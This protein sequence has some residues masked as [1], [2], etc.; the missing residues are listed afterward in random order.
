MTDIDAPVLSLIVT[1]RNDDHGGNLLGRMQLFIDGWIDQCRR[2]SL[3]SELIIV[4]WNPPAERP[5]LADALSWPVETGPVRV[6]IIQVPND[7]HR[8]F[9]HSESLPLFQ[10]IAKNAGIRRARGEYLLLS[11]VDILFNNE[12]MKF[13][14]SGGLK[15]KRMY[16]IDRHDSDTDVPAD[17]DIDSKLEFCRRHVIRINERDK[18]EN[19]R[20]GDVH[21]VYPWLNRKERVKQW[22]MDMRLIRADSPRRVHTNACGDFTLMHRDHWFELRGYAELQMYS[23]FIDALLCQ[24]A[25][26]AGI[27]ERMIREPCRI[28]HVEHGTGSGFT[29]EGKQ[30]LSKRLS[31][32]GIERLTN[33]QYEEWAIAMRRENRP[34]MFNDTDWGLAGIELAE[35]AVGRT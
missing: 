27:R 31:N 21:S 23:L 19:L 30:K 15:R 13:L 10:M 32:A 24:A 11:N 6:R 9:S 25:C 18:T 28:Y 8:R 29:P 7:L 20:T 35:K 33:E 34:M 2:F 12:L 17:T 1:A 22:L 26:A 16:R 4:E 5:G 14:S 3:A